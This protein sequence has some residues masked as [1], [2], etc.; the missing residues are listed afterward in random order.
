[1]AE[2]DTAAINVNL[3]PPYGSFAQ[4]RYSAIL[5]FCRFKLGSVCVV[6]AIGAYAKVGFLVVYAGSVDMVNDH[7][8]GAVHYLPVHT[9]VTPF[10]WGYSDGSY[11][12]VGG[13]PWEGKPS[14]LRKVVKILVVNK[15]DKASA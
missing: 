8:V 12:V 4:P 6:L 5:G 11:C 9:D 10:I 7:P 15:G 3:S 2:D 1:M 13:S 14:I